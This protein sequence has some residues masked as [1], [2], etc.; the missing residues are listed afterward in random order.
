MYLHFFIDLFNQRYFFRVLHLH[1]IFLLVQ[2]LDQE[3]SFDYLEHI[4][5][6][7]AGILPDLKAIV[8]IWLS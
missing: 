8:Q 1:F 5:E 7:L 2:N 3:L 4:V 6:L